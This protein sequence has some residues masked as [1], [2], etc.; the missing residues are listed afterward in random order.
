MFM[1]SGLRRNDG[2]PEIKARFKEKQL[3]TP[4]C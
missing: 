3:F 4:R 2:A 1:D